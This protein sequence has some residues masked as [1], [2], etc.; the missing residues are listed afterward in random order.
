MSPL[1]INSTRVGLSALAIPSNE[2]PA[3]TR[4]TPLSDRFGL[5]S[6]GS[7]VQSLSGHMTQSPYLQSAAQ[8]ISDGFGILLGAGSLEDAIEQMMALQTRQGADQSGQAK[9]NAQHR[10][11]LSKEQTRQRQ[12][13][14]R[15]QQEAERNRSFWDK[16]GQLFKDIFKA[17]VAAVSVVVGAVT[18]TLGAV[19]GAALKL[20]SI[21]LSRTTS[22]ETAKWLSL[23]LGLLGSAASFDSTNVGENL[24]DVELATNGIVEGRDGYFTHDISKKTANKH[25]LGAQ[26]IDTEGRARKELDLFEEAISR[27][28]R[29][30][31]RALGLL[32]AQQGGALAAM[33]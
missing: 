31:R 21:I 1:T 24:K 29:L 5:G 26:L 7:V 17:V 6:I 15:K 9:R 4:P 11:A 3:L 19:V 2:K 33:S 18:G 27:Q 12:E 25:L 16:I 13:A 8:K 32:D 30:A 22:G 14:V 10:F 20:T 28:G 23:G